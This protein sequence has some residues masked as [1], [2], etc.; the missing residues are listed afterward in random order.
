MWHPSFMWLALMHQR[1]PPA[2][3]PFLSTTY[4]TQDSRLSRT[5]VIRQSYKCRVPVALTRQVSIAAQRI[6][7]ES[8]HVAA[9]TFMHAHVLSSHANAMLSCE[10]AQG[11]TLQCLVPPRRSMWTIFGPFMHSYCNSEQTI[12]TLIKTNGVQC[13]YYVL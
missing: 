12:C 11:V 4:G 8:I 5:T 2:C 9:L 7:Q 6:L 13:L 1:R 10:L 3:F